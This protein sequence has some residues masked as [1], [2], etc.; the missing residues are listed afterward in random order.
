M[1]LIILTASSCIYMFIMKIV[2]IKIGLDLREGSFLI[3]FPIR[4]VNCENKI[5]IGFS[6]Y[7]FSDSNGVVQPVLL[8]LQGRTIQYGI[9]V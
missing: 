8:L 1:S 5:I 4:F 7:L 6:S 3:F 2:F 9:I